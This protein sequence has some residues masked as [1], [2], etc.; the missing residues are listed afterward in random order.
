MRRALLILVCG[1]VP[2]CAG[3]TL[4]ATPIDNHKQVAVREVEDFEG[5]GDERLIDVVFTPGYQL[6]FPGA[7]AMDA[8]GHAHLLAGFRAAFPDLRVTVEEQVAEGDR[9]VNHIRLTGT[10]EGP[11]QGVP[12]TH[13]RVSVTGTNLMRF[14][15]G[16]IAELWGFLDALGM[17]Q[18]LGVLPTQ[19]EPRGRASVGPRDAS[20]PEA[21][22]ALVRSFVERFNAHDPEGLS[23]VFGEAY[24]LDFPGGP[25]GDGVAGVRRAT[26]EFIAAFPD[27]RFG[28]DDLVAER[29]LVAWRW[30]LTGTH[31]GPLGPVPASGRPV[32]IDG[33]SLLR[34]QAGRIVE[35]RVRADVVGLMQQIGAMPSPAG[36]P[37]G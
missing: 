9:V 15:G 13:R 20:P 8:R 35:D 23:R 16:K 34:V 10:H 11:F 3:P 1:A 2:A 14:E 19:G 18:Q 36:P 30:T 6:H 4:R 26:T 32:R 24:H 27:L 25:S 29:G 5:R 12:A 28:T 17:M 21:A 22:K 33:L 7:P 37:P 31:R